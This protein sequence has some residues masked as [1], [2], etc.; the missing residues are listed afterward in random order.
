[1]ISEDLKEWEKNIQLTSME[2]A[3]MV[4]SGRLG[5]DACEH[6]LEVLDINDDE[7]GILQQNLEEILGEEDVSAYSTLDTSNNE[8]TQ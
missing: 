3:W 6:V 1:M 4:L 8:E 5:D 2:I 7:A